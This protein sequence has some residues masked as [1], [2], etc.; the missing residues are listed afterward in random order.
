MDSFLITVV[1]ITGRS[2]KCQELLERFNGGDNN[3][4][5]GLYFGIENY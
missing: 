4:S 5:P 2:I 1:I 3:G